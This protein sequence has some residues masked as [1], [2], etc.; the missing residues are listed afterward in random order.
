MRIITTVAC[1]CGFKTVAATTI[2]VF[3]IAA[4]AKVIHEWEYIISLWEQVKFLISFGGSFWGGV[5]SSF[6]GIFIFVWAACVFY[7]LD[8]MLLAELGDDAKWFKYL[9]FIMVVGFILWGVS[10]LSV[11]DIF[12]PM[13]DWNAF[14]GAAFFVVLSPIVIAVLAFCGAV[15]ATAR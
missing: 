15:L 6:F 13:K 11:W 8:N 14:H 7:H 12:S 4:I 9:K 2:T 3:F 5:V 10:F 1:A